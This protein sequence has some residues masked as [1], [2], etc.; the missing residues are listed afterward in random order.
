MEKV[1]FLGNSC[2]MICKTHYDTDPDNSE[3]IDIRPDQIP[4]ILIPSIT[5]CFADK[6]V[7]RMSIFLDMDD[8]E[9]NYVNCIVYLWDGITVLKK[10]VY[11]FGDGSYD[12][13]KSEVL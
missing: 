13:H 5:K 11:L 8:P 7:L 10:H 4:E 1:N 2:V 9:T 3:W 12:I 6:T